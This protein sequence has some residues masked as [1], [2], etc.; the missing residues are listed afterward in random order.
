M[1]LTRPKKPL[2]ILKGSCLNSMLTFSTISLELMKVKSIVDFSNVNF[3]SSSFSFPTYIGN[4]FSKSENLKAVP[5]AW[6][7]VV[8]PLGTVILTDSSLE[9]NMI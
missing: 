7:I 4:L 8:L 6:I 1:L 9:L 3:S 5:I 2:G